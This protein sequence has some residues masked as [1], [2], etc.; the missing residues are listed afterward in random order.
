MSSIPSLTD[1]LK[2]LPAGK[3]EPSNFAGTGWRGLPISTNVDDQRGQNLLETQ[4]DET[5]TLIGELRRL[6]ALLA[7]EERP[8][9]QKYG[10]LAMPGGGR[11]G[12]PGASGYPRGG[13]PPGGNPPGS[14]GNPPPTTPG[15]TPPPIPGP[16]GQ[17]MPPWGATTTG[18]E[19]FGGG[20]GGGVRWRRSGPARQPIRPGADEG[21]SARRRPAAAAAIRRRNEGWQRIALRL[22][23]QLESDPAMRERF[24]RTGRV[25][26]ETQA[27][28]RARSSHGDDDRSCAARGQTVDQGIETSTRQ[29]RR[30]IFSGSRITGRTSSN[31]LRGATSMIMRIA[32]KGRRAFPGREGNTLTNRGNQGTNVG[33]SVGEA[34]SRA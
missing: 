18:P 32:N 29:E 33:S 23:K 15:G 8:Q 20:T 24:M 16:Y 28:G 10:A 6:N 3:S 27:I 34:S 31:E 17:P 22:M 11:A 9:G 5:K 21:A 25:R 30:K 19:A 2:S 12:I 7:G 4:N 14:S 13:G 26:A 1:A